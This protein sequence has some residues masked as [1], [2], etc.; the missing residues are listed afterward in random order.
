MKEGLTQA[1]V[2]QRQSLREF[3]RWMA[4]GSSGAELFSSRGLEASVV[5]STPQRG[6]PNSVVY[7]GVE[8]LDRG[9]PKLDAAYK[10]AEICAWTVWVPE[11][12]AEVIAMLGDARLAFDGDPAAM[13]LR[14]DDFAPPELG[15]LDWDCKCTAAQ[16]A[17]IN[18]D[19]YG[20]G[21]ADGWG[22]ALAR[23]ATAPPLRLYRAKVGGK[24]AATVVTIDAQAEAGEGGDLGVYCVATKRSQ[25]GK[26]LMSRLLG[27][28]LV[29]G[30]ERGLV[31]STLQASAQGEP[32]YAK[33]GYETRFRWHMYERRVAS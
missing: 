24:P 22:P 1:K 6:I 20:H 19:A 30:R 13:E 28:V 10:R 2:L 18:D 12:D 31:S 7:D 11:D 26:G 16:C 3:V 27:Q 9:L 23:S 4:A 5:P 17:T 25:Q 15:D 33:L 8:A 32:V 14:L 21:P 29:E